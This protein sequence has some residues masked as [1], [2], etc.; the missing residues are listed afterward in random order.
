MRQQTT[1]GRRFW[2]DLYQVH[3]AADLFPML[4]EDDVRKLGEDIKTNG[5]REPIILW[6]PG[7]DEDKNQPT[8]LL[9]G[10]NRL[11]AIELVTGQGTFEDGHFHPKGLPHFFG[12]RH[13]F[14]FETRW[15]GA[16][17]QGSV[18]PGV[19]PYAYVISKNI[20][21][22]H[23]TKEQQ[24]DLIV[25]VLKAQTD[26]ASSARS[27]KRAGHGRVQG[28]TKDPLKAKAVEQAKQHGISQRTVEKALAKDNRL[29]RAGEAEKIL[30]DGLAGLARGEQTV[31]EA[32]RKI[33]TV[34]IWN[35]EE[36]ADRIDAAIDR[37]L[38]SADNDERIYIGKRLQMRSHFLVRSKE[39]PPGEREELDNGA[40]PTNSRSFV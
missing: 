32:K 26:L 28:S 34:K 29:R 18:V 40:G 30:S 21:R 9:D 38:K 1:K 12:P 27:V 33:M 5:L 24:A 19:D 17:E 39:L 11:T 36:A 7:K 13:E 14:E 22:R 20:L 4:S 23:L 25:S 6:S 2:S 8:Y 35:A 16:G 31:S 37:E 10:R 3:P 15:P